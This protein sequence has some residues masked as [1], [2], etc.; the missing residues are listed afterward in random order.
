MWIVSQK[1]CLLVAGESGNCERQSSCLI[2]RQADACLCC[3]HNNG[4]VVRWCTL[5]CGDILSFVLAAQT[6]LELGLEE[7]TNELLD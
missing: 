5:H 7:C 6:E 4:G 2:L 3:R 1:K